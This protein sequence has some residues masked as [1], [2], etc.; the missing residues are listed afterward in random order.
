[1]L[2]SLLAE[3]RPLLADGATGTNL[4]A[5][6]LTSGDAPEF[7]NAEHPD[8]IQSLH[9]AFVDAGSDI[10]LTNSFGANRRRLMLHKLEGRTRELNRLAAEIARKVA[11][12]AG[13]PVVVAG[14]IGPTGDLIAPLGP[15]SED[16]AVD[17]FTEQIEGLRQGGADVAW[18]ETMSAPEE[19]RAAAV[20]AG[21]CGMPY[22][23]TAS[24]DTA[25][26][27]MMGVAPAAFSELVEAFDPAPLAFGANCGV[28]A[29]DLLAA[30]LG[31]KSGARADREG[32]RRRAAM[33]WGGNPLFRHAGA[34]GEVCRTRRGLRRAHHRRLLRQQ[35]GPCRGYAAR[36]RRPRH[37]RAARCGGDRRGARS[38]RRAASGGERRRSAAPAGADVNAKAKRRAWSLCSRGRSGRAGKRPGRRGAPPPAGCARRSAGL[39]RWRRERRRAARSVPGPG[40]GRA[41]SRSV[42]H[43]AQGA[44][45][46]RPGKGRRKRCARSFDTAHGG[47]TDRLRGAVAGGIAPRRRGHQACRDL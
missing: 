29:S 17:V 35:P 6:G 31:M 36:P 18:I 13:R 1:M 12:S 42:A 34:D 3:G 19:I 24:F 10:I 39:R 11:D 37:R 20:A 43:P 41:K 15:L 27:T 5:M 26:R 33:A 9:Q 25:G 14:S 30:I 23:V 47:R 44:D 2:Q 32:E 22:T 45:R 28:G 40:G 38:P 16:E 7:W 8:R 46:G 21:K 4:F